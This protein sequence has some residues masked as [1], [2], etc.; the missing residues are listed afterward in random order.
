[1]LICKSNPMVVNMSETDSDDGVE[2][3]QSEI[4]YTLSCSFTVFARSYHM[5]QN[6]LYMS[7]FEISIY[8]PNF[9]YSR[10][11]TFFLPEYL[12]SGAGSELLN[13]STMLSPEE[14]PKYACSAT[15]NSGT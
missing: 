15:D 12:P 7:Y 5:P 3:V 1:M 2:V 4:R 11:V 10:I 14:K 13:I 8:I 9:F 6:L